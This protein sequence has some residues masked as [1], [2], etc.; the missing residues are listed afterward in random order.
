MKSV[1]S[2]LLVGVDN[3]THYILF[4]LIDVLCVHHC[5]T[6]EPINQ[7]FLYNLFDNILSIR[8]IPKLLRHLDRQAFKNLVSH[9]VSIILRKCSFLN[10]V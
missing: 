6:L 3:S 10:V 4:N 7:S 9:T 1:N 2:N 5:F 8:L